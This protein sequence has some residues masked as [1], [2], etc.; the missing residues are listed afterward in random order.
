ML[1][2]V[3]G[4][5]PI[6]PARC[7]GLYERSGNHERG[8]K[9]LKMLLTSVALH[10]PS[11]RK[12]DILA[13]GDVQPGLEG[14]ERLNT[15]AKGRAERNLRGAQG[16]SQG[17]TGGGVRDTRGDSQGR[18]GGQSWM[19]T[20]SAWPPLPP[21]TPGPARKPPP[22]P[23]Y[24]Q[25]PP[26]PPSFAHTSP[27]FNSSHPSAPIAPSWLMAQCWPPPPPCRCHGAHQSQAAQPS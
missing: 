4:A 22:T 5:L 18:T 16:G 1:V 14:G 15:L 17:H 7:A 11:P 23:A 19:N 21:A 3:C 12:Q 6:S 27:P 9:R 25:P 20:G 26:S 8:R 24:P 13:V 10:S 2:T